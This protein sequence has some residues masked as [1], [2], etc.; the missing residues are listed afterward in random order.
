MLEP[1]EKTVSR[2]YLEYDG[3]RIKFRTKR[4][5]VAHGKAMHSAGYD[6]K[7]FEE[8]DLWLI[9]PDKQVHADHQMF[10][11]TETWLKLDIDD[12]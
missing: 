10:D 3:E 2:Y 11:R 7:M 8:Y 6:V 1:K 5:C 9:Y 12:L 4:L